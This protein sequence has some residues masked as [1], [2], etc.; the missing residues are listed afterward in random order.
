MRIAVDAWLATDPRN[1]PD[2]PPHP[3]VLPEYT[4]MED[5]LAAAAE[6]DSSERWTLA[7]EYDQRADR[8]VLLTVVFASV[9]FFAGISE[10]FEEDHV[11]IGILIMGTLLFTGAFG[12]ML[13]YP[14]WL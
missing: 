11:R 10:K 14:V 13:S 7:R 8:Y 6:A 3:F 2:A 5:S 1:N 12:M 4:V 9:L